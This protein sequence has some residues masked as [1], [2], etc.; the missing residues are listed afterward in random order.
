MYFLKPFFTT[1]VAVGSAAFFPSATHARLLSDGRRLEAPVTDLV[2]NTG[3]DFESG[4]PAGFSITNVVGGPVA[5]DVAPYGTNRCAI[6]YI[7]SIG[8]F[9]CADSDTHKGQPYDTSVVSN[10]IDL[11]DASNAVLTYDVN[12]QDWSSADFFDTDI[13][14]PDGGST[15]IIL[16]SWNES[17]G[18][19][20]VGG[21]GETVI[22]NLDAYVGQSVLIR[23]RYYSLAAN[24]WDW[25]VQLDNIGLTCTTLPPPPPT[26]PCPSNIC[27]NRGNKVEICH[28]P[29]GNPSKKK[30]LCVGVDGATDH[31]AKTSYCGPCI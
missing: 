10:V 15:W 20:R 7:G 5:F 19:F 2:C 24:P 21:P 27:G 11:T 22:L 13:L 28:V 9:L 17:Y 8:S 31:I 23:W 1:L 6:N 30:T 16:L 25:F 12:Y 3:I 4:L 18:E 26:N 29:P 14:S